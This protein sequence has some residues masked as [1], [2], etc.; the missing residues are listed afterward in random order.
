VALSRLLRQY[1][2]NRRLPWRQDDAPTGMIFLPP[3]WRRPHMTS[4]RGENMMPPGLPKTL[5]R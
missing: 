2:F 1:S 3:Q 5:I 4:K